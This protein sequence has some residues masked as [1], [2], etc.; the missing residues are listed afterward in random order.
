MRVR[1][2][3]RPSAIREL[4]DSEECALEAEIVLSFPNVQTLFDPV[5]DVKQ[6]Y[7]PS[8]SLLQTAR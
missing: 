5:L 4:V 2:Y 1:A 8:D 3:G 6:G 7:L